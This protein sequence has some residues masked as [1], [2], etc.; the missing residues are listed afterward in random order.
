MRLI[1]GPHIPPPWR[2]RRWLRQEDNQNSIVLADEFQASIQL[3][4][5][6]DSETA[7]AVIKRLFL[8]SEESS[9]TRS[10]N[11]MPYSHYLHLQSATSAR[12]ALPLS[13]CQPG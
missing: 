9:A 5:L 4:T 8:E 7:R 13:P 3:R 11:H 6:R 10:E 2:H 1:A 12:D